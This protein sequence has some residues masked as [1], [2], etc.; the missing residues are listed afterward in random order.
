MLEVVAALILDQDKFLIAQRGK[1]K[2][3]GLLWEFVGGKVERGES[4]EKALIRE[5]QEELS[6][7]LKVNG[8]I[9]EVYY[10]YNDF[11]IDLTLFEAQIDQGEVTISEHNAISWITTSDIDNYEF[12]PADKLFLNKIKELYSPQK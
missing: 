7:T 4:K 8:K 6:I 9:S 5:C 3:N 10:D 11:T 1:E 12:C 2:A